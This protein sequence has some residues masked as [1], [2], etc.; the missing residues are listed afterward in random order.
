MSDENNRVWI[1]GIGLVGAAG[2]GGGKFVGRLDETEAEFQSWPPDQATPGGDAQLALVGDY[3][4]ERYF[5]ERQLRLTDRAMAMSTCAVGLALQ[6]AGWQNPSEIGNRDDVAT[7]FGSMRAEHPSTQKFS[8]PLLSG[9]PKS[10]NPAQFPMIARN[11]TCGQIAITFGVRG[12][13]SMMCAGPLSS[14]HAI[15]RGADLVRRRRSTVALVGGIETLGK[16]SINHSRHLY[17]DA[18]SGGTPGFFSTTP[19]RLVPGEGSAMLVLE[20]ATS[21]RQRGARPYAEVLG[22]YAGRLGAALDGASIE[23]E[24]SHF[25]ATQAPHLE[26][27]TDAWRDIA[28]MTCGNSGAGTLQD[29]MELQFLEAVYRKRG[30][31]VPLV[32]PRS[33]IGEAEAT[34]SA[35]Q[36]Q[37]AA[38]ALHERRIPATKNLNIH[39]TSALCAFPTATAIEGTSQRALVCGFDRAGSYSFLLLARPN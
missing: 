21:A 4:K 8:V 23:Q 35:L 18:L 36:V 32:A 25:L 17:G 3:P 2:Y 20:N 39:D 12:M 7:I 11:V 38:V 27:S 19:G 10:L 31:R 33:W 5:S 30:V 34:A 13:S 29:T 1:T 16:F 28:L 22:A 24:V 37:A 14:L 9:K 15:A 6:D 26:T